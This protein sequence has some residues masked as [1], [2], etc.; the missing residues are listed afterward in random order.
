MTARAETAE[1]TRSRILAAAAE[2]AGERFLDEI[3]LEDVA[4]RAGVAVRTVIRRFG[5]RAALVEAAIAGANAQVSGRRDETRPGDIV[6]A[7]NALFDDY[8][9]WG[10][11]LLMVLA[12]EQRHPELKPLLDEGREMHQR[13]VER[14]FSPRDELHTAQLAAVTDVYV[15][16]LLRRDMKLSRSGAALALQTMIE[17]LVT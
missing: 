4:E 14:V 3:S 8:E 9:R 7:V 6:D 2:L 13:W 17:R 10:D 15:W 1:R 12:Q 11:P 5:T 16:K